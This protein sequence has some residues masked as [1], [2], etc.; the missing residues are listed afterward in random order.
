MRL[1]YTLI[2]SPF[3]SLGITA[4]VETLMRDCASTFNLIQSEAGGAH[5]FN[6]PATMEGFPLIIA[7]TNSW[8][9]LSM[10][11]GNNNNVSLATIVKNLIS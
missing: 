2:T 3:S 11:R 5:Y 10:L 9:I 8:Y 6:S 4:K 1:S 7:D